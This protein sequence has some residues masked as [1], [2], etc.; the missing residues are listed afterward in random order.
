MPFEF[1]KEIGLLLR[2]LKVHER[3]CHFEHQLLATT[4]AS[5]IG[6]LCDVGKLTPEQVQTVAVWILETGFQKQLKKDPA[7]QVLKFVLP[8]VNLNEQPSV[9]YLRLP[10]LKVEQVVTQN[11]QD[12][13]QSLES[14]ERMVPP[15]RPEDN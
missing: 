10:V 2:A 11:L 7:Q 13:V 15:P 5:L 4:L 3:H 1:E 14:I 12:K 9:A 8:P 6:C